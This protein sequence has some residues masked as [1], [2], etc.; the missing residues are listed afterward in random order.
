[1]K[2]FLLTCYDLGRKMR[3]NKGTKKIERERKGSQR[4]QWFAKTI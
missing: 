4:M 3:R 1:M 2:L